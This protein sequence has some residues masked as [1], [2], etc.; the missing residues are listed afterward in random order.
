MRKEGLPIKGFCVVTD[1]PSIGK[2]AEIIKGLANVDIKHVAFKPGLFEGI[3]QVVSIAAA[4]PSF[5][6]ISQWIGGHTGGHHSY[7]NTSLFSLHI[8]RS[9]ST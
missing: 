4:N 8:G 6:I 2:A 3:R 7:K 1:I 5:P 9:G